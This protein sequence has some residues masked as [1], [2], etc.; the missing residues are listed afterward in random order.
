MTPDVSQASA[1]CHRNGRLSQ[2]RCARVQRRTRA[3]LRASPDGGRVTLSDINVVDAPAFT[4]NAA[5]TSHPPA[6]DK[7]D[8]AS[9][10]ETHHGRVD[11]SGGVTG[12]CLPTSQGIA[13]ATVDCSVVTAENKRATDRKD[14][15]K[16]QPVIVAN[17]QH[18]AIEPILK[19][20]VVAKGYLHRAGIADQYNAWRKRLLIADGARIIH[21]DSIGQRIG[22]RFRH[23]K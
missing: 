22:G 20:K 5:V 8:E 14:V 18:P 3:R 21:K 23:G 19:V 10:R 4:G 13:T 1:L 7:L 12:P 9:T 2:R 6:E 16:G 17:L 15:L 11:K